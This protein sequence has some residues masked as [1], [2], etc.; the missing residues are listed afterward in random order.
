MRMN[1][2]MDE[3]QRNGEPE[4]S[5]EAFGSCLR[6]MLVRSRNHEIHWNDFGMRTSGICR[7]FR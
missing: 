4:S 1:E 2:R 7:V 3:S 6:G 5:R